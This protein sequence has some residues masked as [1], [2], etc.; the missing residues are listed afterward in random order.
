MRIP[1]DLSV[2]MYHHKE[3]KRVDKEER[4]KLGIMEKDKQF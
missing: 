4:R 2:E 3:G 1:C